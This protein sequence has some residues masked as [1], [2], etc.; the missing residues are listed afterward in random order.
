MKNITFNKLEEMSY[1]RR[2]AMNAL[3]SNL[4]FSGS[5]VKKFLITSTA[6]N[7]GKSTIA[8]DLARSMAEAGNKVIFLDMDMRKSVTT[9]RYQVSVD[10]KSE[11]M[12][13]TQLLSGMASAKEVLCHTNIEKM[14][15]ILAGKLTP[16]P[17]ALIESDIFDVLLEA[18]EKAYDYIIIDS[19]PIGAVIDAA[20]IGRKT[21]GV[22]LVA[23]YN[24]TTYRLMSRAKKQL[25]MLQCNILGTVI[26]KVPTSG[27]S[28]YKYY[29]EY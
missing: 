14:D 17:T 6:P 5:R 22:V 15:V 16:N 29:G 8:F 3:R 23:N 12:G 13:M 19:P 18:L 9:S 27:S 11:I 25:E 28:Y 7:D 10:D 2:E 1:S 4:Q 26:N 21:D 20:T 24:K